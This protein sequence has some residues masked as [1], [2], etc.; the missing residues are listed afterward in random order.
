[1][2]MEQPEKIYRYRSF[3]EQTIDSLC[4]DQL[5]FANPN[6]F[7]DP[8]DCQPTIQ[9]DSTNEEMSAILTE[10]VKNNHVKKWRIS[11]KEWRE[12]RS[13]SQNSL[14]WLLLANSS[15]TNIL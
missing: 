1:M 11:I 7:N 4:M 5:Y 12:K 9:A 15:S 13:I 6:S 10:L 14:Y 2:E 3:S 8:M